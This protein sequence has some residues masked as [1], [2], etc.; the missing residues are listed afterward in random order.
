MNNLDA[1]PLLRL[2]SVAYKIIGHAK[3]VQL[4]FP[5]TDELVQGTLDSKVHHENPLKFA[6]RLAHEKVSFLDLSIRLSEIRKTDGGPR[7]LRPLLVPIHSSSDRPA[8]DPIILL[9]RGN[10]FH[11]KILLGQAKVLMTPILICWMVL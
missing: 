10:H 1:T 3:T 9:G 4:Y 6:M 11:E 7:V 2:A 5:A 8:R